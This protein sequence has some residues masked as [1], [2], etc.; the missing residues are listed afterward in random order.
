MLDKQ[1][2]LAV[3]KLGRLELSDGEVEKFS[4]QLS[5][6]LD[7]FKKIDDIDLEGVEE[8]SQITG[9]NN[10]SRKDEIKCE[11]DRTCCTADE[12]LSNIPD[13]DGNLI[14]VPKI[15]EGK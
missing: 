7:M 9:L 3:A 11:E 15:L 13:R 4:A 1:E 5:D 14:I 6:V 12:L 8:T 10:V 2:V